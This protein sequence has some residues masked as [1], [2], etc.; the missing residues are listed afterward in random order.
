[1]ATKLY[2][3]DLTPDT[4]RPYLVPSV[5]PAISADQVTLE[6]NIIIKIPVATAAEN[7][8]KGNGATAIVN[9][10][11]FTVD[12]PDTTDWI[13]DV[14][15]DPYT[16]KLS[17]DDNGTELGNAEDTSIAISAVEIANIPVGEAEIVWVST[18]FSTSAKT[19]NGFNDGTAPDL[20][21]ITYTINPRGNTSTHLTP[22][23][24][25][26]VTLDDELETDVYSFV[27]PSGE[28]GV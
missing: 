24:V 14:F 18:G 7:T 26:T 10:A 19:I 4:T 23:T 15:A 17:I 16:G 21:R 27:F 8:A 28:E 22:N 3:T 5:S 1:M 20:V 6:T 2:H 12:V 25:I 11:A 13:L 9:K